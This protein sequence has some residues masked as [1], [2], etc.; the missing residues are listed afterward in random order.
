MPAGRQSRR[1]LVGEGADRRRLRRGMTLME[2][3][4]AVVIML[5]LAGILVPS[6]MSVFQ[7]RE[8]QAA[9]RIALLYQTL[10]DEAQLKNITFR[11]TFDLSSN[12]YK[13]EM[14]EPGA[15]IFADPEARERGLQELETR[16]KLMDEDALARYQQSQKPFERLEE[17]VEELNQATELPPGIRLYGVYTPQYGRVTIDDFDADDEDMKKSPLVS[18]HIFANGFSERT[19]IW[20]VD[21]DDT[22]DGFTIEVEPLSGRVHLHGE[23]L[24]PEDLTDWVPREGPGL[25][26]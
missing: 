19:I 22:T 6:A 4:V 1:H 8:R 16:L 18:S 5:L 2:V 21:A 13:V 3:M 14:G 24:D 26:S 15:M 17:A 12:A 9:Q 23:L 11:I 10:H 25:P 20:I 7:V